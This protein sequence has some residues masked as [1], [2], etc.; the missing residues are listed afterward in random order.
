MK[1]ILKKICVLC[2]IPIYAHTMSLDKATFQ[3]GQRFLN[4]KL[5]SE[6]EM[7]FLDIV[8]KYPDSSYYRQSLFYLGQTYAHQGKY[9]SALQYYKILMN[10]SRTTKERQL[11]LLGIAKSWLQMGVHD[12]AAQFY[13]FFAS[14]YPESEHAPVSLYFAGISREREGNNKAAVEKFRALISQYPETDYYAKSIE[15]LAVLESQTPEELFLASSANKKSSSYQRSVSDIQLFADDDFN[16]DEVPNF[17]NTDFRGQAINLGTPAPLVLTPSIVTQTILQ[18]SQPTV[19]TQQVF[20]TLTQF[21]EKPP[22]YIAGT[23]AQLTTPSNVVPEIITP[24]ISTELNNLQNSSVVQL[25]NNQFTP[26][27]TTAQQ[28]HKAELEAYKKKWEAE[29]KAKLKNAELQEAEQSVKDLLQLTQ[30][31]AD[32]LSVKEADL[33]EK[34]NQLKGN[35]YRDLKNVNPDFAVAPQFNNPPSFTGQK[36]SAPSPAPETNI[37]PVITSPPMPAPE[38]NPDPVLEEEADAYEEISNEDDEYTED[39]DE[40]LISYDEI[41]DGE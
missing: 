34:Q 22:V 37:S 17:N 41:E 10:K 32:V 33:L 30:S 15:K 3:V 8:R 14:E 6:A 13:S 16:L 35:I 11:A 24:E 5:F 20:Q 4:Q 23:N 28:I 21:V 31:K 9:E 2:L 18:P 12:K 26:L 40:D 19:V 1:K 7:R 29:F 38:S 39:F 36:K 27:E 25:S